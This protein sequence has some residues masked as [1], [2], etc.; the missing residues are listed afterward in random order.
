MA[1]LLVVLLSACNRDN[2][3]SQVT[4]QPEALAQSSQ[5]IT[6]AR[7]GRF[8]LRARVAYADIQAIAS[9]ELPA[10]HD[11]VDS[12]RLCKRILGIKA[13]GTANWDL[14]VMRQGEIQ[15]SGGNERVA[16]KT[17][18]TFDGVVGM[19]GKVARALGLSSLDV[20]G[21]VITQVNLGLS[22]Q[23]D[24]CPTLS[25]QVS[26]DWVEKP[27]VVWR[28][29][30]DFNLEKVVNDALDKQLASL[31]P[32][33]NKAIN[34]IQFREQLA[35]YW[36]SYTFALDIPGAGSADSAQQVH[37]NIV[38]TGFAFSGIRTEPEKLGVSFALDA[39]TVVASEPLDVQSIALPPLQQ[40]DFQSSKTD[41]DILLRAD[42]RQLQQAI[43]PRVVGK[44]YTSDS[45]AGPVTVT[46]TSIDFSGN[47]EGVTVAL[48]FNANLPTNRRDTT[49]I[50]YLNA[51]PVVDTQREQLSLQNVTLSKV[52]DSTLWNIISSVFEGQ[53]IAAIERNA[54]FNLAERARQLEQRLTE[55]L[56]DPTRTGGVHVRA[57]DLTIKLLEIVPEYDA[58]AARARVSASLD[59]DIPLTVIKRPLQ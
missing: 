52:L 30:L 10:S 15:I 33:L 58:L 32:R 44:T 56:H 20:Q 54:V 11:I 31:E 1:L 47:T 18:L 26:Y 24:W 40:V 21:A 13:C 42:Y 48:G 28:N 6:E 55:Q 41:F 12:R 2:P 59:L 19:E 22:L 16:I 45:P 39:T 7:P 53:I 37:L 50:L 17:P 57:E 4:E 49:G 5:A 9:S 14:T 46:L 36:R 23:D 51:K 29:K 8:G 3:T 34:C 25:A 38:P 35:S 27:T 43:Q